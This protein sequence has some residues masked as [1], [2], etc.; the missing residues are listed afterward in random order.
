MYLA[1][2]NTLLY[3][4]AKLSVTVG[5]T[6]PELPRIIKFTREDVAMK[7]TYAIE[8]LQR[9]LKTKICVMLTLLW[10]AQFNANFLC[11]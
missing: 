7:A 3:V 5:L 8:F 9:C 4:E 10:S 1:D 11:F 6:S 2:S